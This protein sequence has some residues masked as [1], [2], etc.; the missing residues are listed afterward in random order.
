MFMVLL[1]FSEGKSRASEH[2]EEHKAWIQASR[3]L[4]LAIPYAD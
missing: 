3:A 1:K 2:V 4:G